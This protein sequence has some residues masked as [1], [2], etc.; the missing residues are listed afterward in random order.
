MKKAHSNP[1]A[2]HEPGL[3]YGV[4][5][6]TTWGPKWIDEINVQGTSQECIASSKQ[7]RQYR[8]DEYG[9]V[10]VA[11]L[12]EMASSPRN[13]SVYQRMRR[14]LKKVFQLANVPDD[15]T[16]LQKIATSI[17]KQLPSTSPQ[18]FVMRTQEV[19]PQREALDRIR[20]FP[21]V[22]PS[23]GQTFREQAAVN[24]ILELSLRD[25]LSNVRS[26]DGKKCRRWLYARFPHHRFC[27]EQCKN[28]Y[29]A[30]KAFKAEHAA[31]QKQID[32]LHRSGKVKTKFQMRQSPS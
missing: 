6:D 32:E 3:E 18:Y 30:S 27:S 24:A 4:R 16:R 29:Y 21:Q 10:L 31:K 14:L 20:F 5:D 11:W 22:V 2:K 17:E 12:N 28:Q 23:G 25:L 9:D 13:R 26:C 15:Q 8:G 1:G 19:G 7:R